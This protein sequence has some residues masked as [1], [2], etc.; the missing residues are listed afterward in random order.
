[1]AM[2]ST[3]SIPPELQ[4]NLRK[5]LEPGENVVWAQ[6]PQVAFVSLTTMAP[7]F[8]GVVWMGI[9]LFWFSH[10]SHNFFNQGPERI[11]IVPVLGFGFLAIGVAFLFSPIWIYH[12]LQKTLYLITD[13]RA[14]ILRGTWPGAAKSYPPDRFQHIYAKQHRDGMGKVVFAKR[15][16]H[17]S[18]GQRRTEE[19]GFF[20]ISEPREAEQLLKTL[21]SHQ[22]F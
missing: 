10:L 3:D 20:N 8:F 17:D 2:P 7:F 4:E 5:H 16:W 6:Q 19:I 12:R 11:S 14:L 1:M 21:A 18:N 22:G 13:R 15:E 9:T